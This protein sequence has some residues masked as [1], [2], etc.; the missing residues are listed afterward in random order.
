[1]PYSALSQV[2]DENMADCTDVEF[3]MSTVEADLI[4]ISHDQHIPDNF[5]PR[6]EYCIF[7]EN[8]AYTGG[9]A[10]NITVLD[11]ADLSQIR[12]LIDKIRKKNS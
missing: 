4:F 2:I 8:F 11:C 9:A 6:K 10:Q 3:T 12:S 1:M 7:T 5:D